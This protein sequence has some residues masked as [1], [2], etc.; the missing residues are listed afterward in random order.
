M[1]KDGQPGVFATL[2]VGRAAHLGIYF[3]YDVSSSLR[4]RGVL[5]ADL[6]P[7]V[8]MHRFAR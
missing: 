3:M 5:L 7:L 1:P 6:P 4:R 2:S 8:D